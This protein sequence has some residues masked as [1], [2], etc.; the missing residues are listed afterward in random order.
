MTGTEDRPTVEERYTRAIRSSDLEV[1]EQR[2]DVD[3]LIAAG[4]CHETLGTMLYR[5][6]CEFDSVKSEQHLANVEIVRAAKAI[7]AQI[8]A[9]AEVLKLKPEAK[10]EEV[11]AAE[12]RAARMR[13]DAEAMRR[14][15]EAAHVTA[16]L[17]I[18]QRMKS[19]DA[20]KAALGRWACVQATRRHFMQNDADVVRLAGRVLNVFLDPTCSSCQ[21]RGRNGGY[22]SVQS[23]CRACSGSGKRKT[24]LGKDAVERWFAQHLLA[25]M[26]SMLAEIDR[27]MRRY[28]RGDG[29]PA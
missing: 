11:E 16:R 26:E 1:D 17:L 15:A 9:A 3:M 13:S 25:E 12:Y 6:A 23:I 22:G 8:E 24:N 4:W 7:D 20:T 28:L 21:G 29:R 5:L 27:Q 18:L 19:L 10:Q 14:Q 2:G